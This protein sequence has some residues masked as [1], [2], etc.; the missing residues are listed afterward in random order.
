MVTR[1]VQEYSVI[2]AHSRSIQ[3]LLAK[4]KKSY[5]GNIVKTTKEHF[6]LFQAECEKWVDFFA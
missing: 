3:M 4:E 1:T 5:G 6:K 2:A